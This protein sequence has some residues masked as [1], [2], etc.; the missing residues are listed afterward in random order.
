MNRD[1]FTNYVTMNME[2]ILEELIKEFQE[3]ELPLL[4]ERDLKLPHHLNKIFVI[5]GLRRA[6]KTY[7]LFQLIQGL[8]KNGYRKEEIFYLDFED[9][10]LE[11]FN[12]KDFA[13]IVELYYKFNPK[14][15]TPIFFFDEIQNIKGWEKFI[16]R[17]YEKN[18]AKIFITGSS[19]KLLSKEIA[20]ALRG[21]TLSYQLFPYSFEEFLEAKK[22]KIE[23]PLTERKRG[24]IK[25]LLEEYLTYGGYPEIISFFHREKLK[26]LKEYLDLIIYRDLLERFG[27]KRLPILKL[28]L[29]S[30]SESFAKEFS[31]RRYY[32]FL[33]SQGRKI[34][35]NT[36]YFYFNVLEE[37]NFYFPLKKYSRK[38][39]ET[40]G[41]LPKI[42][43]T[44]LG[45]LT[46]FGKKDI[47]RRMENLVMLQLLRQKE[48]QNPLLQIYYYK[49]RDDK[50]VD[51]VI[52][53]KEGISELIQVCYKIENYKIKER[54]IGSL[55]KVAKE[56]KCNKLIVISWDY[57]GEEKF[58][59]KKVK[60]IPLWKWLLQK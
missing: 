6:G 36:L 59:N 11:E 3:A 29:H 12:V 55:V 20:T 41:S 50:E 15:K 44:D 30:I 25:R 40:E 32:N 10:R 2:K 57:E 4:V 28:L 42:Y 33:K 51:F 7:Y 1:I 53:E 45:Y 31:L 56:L 24:E 13:K 48:Y 47:G 54:E 21:R 22:I 58:A 18:K 34:S 23:L 8:L 39:R 46:L 35:K 16:R 27:I 60:F 37:A 26:V 52:K 38:L 49:T 14:A 43:L 5:Y 9:E 17:V 19:S